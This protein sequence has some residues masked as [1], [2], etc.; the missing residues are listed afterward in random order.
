MLGADVD[1]EFVLQRSAQPVPGVLLVV[2]DEEGR[3]HERVGEKQ[4]YV[5]KNRSPASPRPGTMYARSSSSGSM[6]AVKIGT[7]G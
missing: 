1:I 5:P 3:L 6:E 2:D 7:S 4:P